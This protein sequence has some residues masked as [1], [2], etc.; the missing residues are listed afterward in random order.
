MP[1]PPARRRSCRST[2][3]SSTPW[4]GLAADGYTVEIPESV[5][6]LRAAILD[7]NAQRYGTQANVH[8]RI[9]AE[10]HLRREPYLAEIEA[11]WGPAP[12]RHQTNG[13]EIFVL[14]AQFGNVFVGV[15]PAFGYEGDPMRLLFERGFAPTHAFSAFYRYLREDFSAPTPCCISAPTGRSNSCPASRPACPNPAGRSG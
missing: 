2:P 4:T 14:G 5:D 13:A 10:D 3:R 8:A 11:Q 1:A 9:P 12:G 7:G 15:Q 6:A